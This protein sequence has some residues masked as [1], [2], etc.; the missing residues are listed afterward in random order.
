MAGRTVTGIEVGSRSIN[1]VQVGYGLSG[2]RLTA[3]AS[4]PRP[5]GEDTAVLGAVVHE[6]IDSE[7]IVV[8]SVVSC[9]PGEMCTTRVITLPSRDSEELKAMVQFE[10]GRHLPFPVSEVEMDFILLGDTGEESSEV[11]L[12]AV[13]KDLVNRHLGV[14]H[15]AGLEPSRIDISPLALYNV[16]HAKHMFDKDDSLLLVDVGAKASEIVVVHKGRLALTRTAPVGGGHLTEALAAKLE[17]GLSEC[18][19]LKQEYGLSG[20]GESPPPDVMEV[21]REWA[22][23]LGQELRRS[24]DAFRAARR[25]AT[26]EKVLLAGG[27]SKLAGLPEFLTAELD[28]ETGV[29]N[30]V[31][32]MI[33][34]RQ[35]RYRALVNGGGLAIAVGLAAG[36][37]VPGSVGVNLFPLE[38]R[39][40]RAERKKKKAAAVCALVAAILVAAALVYGSLRVGSVR[41]ELDGLNRRIEATLPTDIDA[42]REQVAVAQDHASTGATLLEL[43]SVL[44]SVLPPDVKLTRMGFRK[45]EVLEISG[46]AKEMGGVRS[47]ER[48]LRQTDH[49][50]DI[51]ERPFTVRRDGTVEYGLICYIR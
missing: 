1:V 19:K 3:A 17:V 42:I 51:D 45:H 14:L 26:I 6:L 4:A 48:L 37:L 36:E 23:R 34:L 11:M 49:F 32:S 22:G 40:E 38:L 46:H 7:R 41:A 29:S 2:L 20:K 39:I 25:G 18:E 35:K 21:T 50:S 12:V 15:E 8:D 16:F 13:R 10:A 5:D 33:G 47:F 30:P 27:G 31:R 9:I 44:S 28:T 43:M 24:L